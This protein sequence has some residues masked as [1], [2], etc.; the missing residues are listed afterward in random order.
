MTIIFEDNFNYYSGSAWTP[1]DSGAAHFVTGGTLQSPGRNEPYNWTGWIRYGTAAITIMPGIGRAGTSALRITPEHPV[2]AASQVGLVKY[3]GPVGY[4]ELYV[5]FH[6]KFSDNYRF[7]NGQNSSFSYHKLFR[8]WQNVQPAEVAG[9][10][11]NLGSE[12]NRGALVG[13]LLDDEWSTFGPCFVLAAMLNTT[14]GTNNCPNDATCET[15]YYNPYS[16][17]NTKGFLNPWTGPL[18][19]G[20]YF[21]QAQDWICIEYHIKLADSFQGT[22][23]LFEIWVNGIKQDTFNWVNAPTP[24]W[25]SGVPR[26]GDTMPTGKLGTGINYITLH[27]NQTGTNYWG[28][29]DRYIYVDDFVV[30]TTYIGPDYIVGGGASPPAITITTTDN[31]TV[32]NTF[33]TIQGNATAQVLSFITNVSCPNQTVTADDSIFDEQIETWTCNVTLKE[34]ANQFTFTATDNNGLT[35][36]DTINVTYQAPQSPTNVFT[37]DNNQTVGTAIFTITGRATAPTGQTITAV[38]CPTATVTAVNAPF[39]SLEED[40]TCTV[41]L[42]PGYNYFQFTILCSNGQ[43]INQQFYV[44]YSVPET[45]RQKIKGFYAR[46]VRIKY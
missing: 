11:G 39:N 18:D 29:T 24:S 35:G 4:D 45:L 16:T 44:T 12:L 43:V 8:F 38:T 7:G 1:S 25:Y 10:T 23:G 6:I 27:D 42:N 40:W 15:F 9:Q 36:V 33:F 22:G 28:S 5:R 21:T 31:Q 13:G 26:A 46:G 17:D 2:A 34:G 41:T 20:G 30:S 3:L 19:T 37:V 32:S 14:A